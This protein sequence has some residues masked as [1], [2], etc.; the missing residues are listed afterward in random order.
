MPTQH[1]QESRLLAGIVGAARHLWHGVSVALYSVLALLETLV[2]GVLFL[3]AL[4]GVG[5]ALVFRFLLQQPNFSFW[6]VLLTSLGC[7]VAAL[8]YYGLMRLLEPRQ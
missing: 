1:I 4:L 7:F 5:V 8:A 2:V 3:V 6:P